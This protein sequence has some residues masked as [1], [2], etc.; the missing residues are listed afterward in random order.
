ME[1]QMLETLRSNGIGK[2]YTRLESPQSIRIVELLPARLLDSTLRFNVHHA[3][4]QDRRFAYTA[5]SYAWGP[6]ETVTYRLVECDGLRAYIPATL[7]SALSRIRSQKPNIRYIWAD[8]L[9]IDQTDSAAAKDEKSAQ[10]SMM[11]QIFA[12]ARE[13]IVDLGELRYEDRTVLST[14][15]HYSSIS[16]TV[17]TSVNVAAGTASVEDS[18]R[19]LDALHFPAAQSAFWKSFQRF[20]CRPWFTRVWIIQE[21]ALACSPQFM[22][23]SHFRDAE[24]LPNAVA[25]A[26]QHLGILYIQDSFYGS[27]PVRNTAIAEAY[28]YVLVKHQAVYR[29]HCA[30]NRLGYQRSLCEL[31]DG[32]TLYFEATDPRDRVYALLGLSDD[33]NIKQDL[34]VDYKEAENDFAI[35]VSLYLS[36]RQFGI[37]PLYHCVGDV[38]GYVSWAL[39]LT[40]TREG[41]ANLIGPSGYTKR[42]MYRACGPARFVR[43]MSDL[44]VHG[45][46]VRGWIVDTISLYMERSMPHDA[47]LKTPQ[48]LEKHAV[49]QGLALDWMLSVSPMQPRPEGEFVKTCWRTVIADLVEPSGGEGHGYRRLRDWP[50]SDRC[51]DTV[52]KVQR[53]AYQKWKGDLPESYKMKLTGTELND[54]RIYAESFSNTLG[55]KLALS[56]ETR[57]PCLVPYDACEGDN[58]VIIQG[59]QI[60]FIL[61]RRDDG[62]GKGE[63]FRIVGCAYVHGIMDGETVGDGSDVRDIEIW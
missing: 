47:Q 7:H 63:Y 2:A 35:R 10:V 33:E 3:S 4:V 19:I 58:I 53:V 48:D 37:Y 11:D 60:P 55:R 38:E 44:R 9:C 54:L 62:D 24:Y 13:V 32:T 40:N 30:R 56:K 17:W 59:C 23:G 31:L 5:V 21:F 29:I 41:L 45:L 46:T 57:T 1:K 20:I 25:R 12:H 18:I 16:D 34:Y 15:D 51:I 50:S 26:A 8:A 52:D 6:P 39:N 14:L 27:N 61:R 43:K 49:W 28:F 22:I 36:R 42:D